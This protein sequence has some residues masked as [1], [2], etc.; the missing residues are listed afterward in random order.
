MNHNPPFATENSQL[1]FHYEFDDPTNMCDLKCYE[2]AC[3]HFRCV[4]V[5]HQCNRYLAGLPC[6]KYTDGPY[7]TGGECPACKRAYEER[8]AYERWRASRRHG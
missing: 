5:I 1:K 2:Y 3:G 6:R 8:V 7:G 4:H